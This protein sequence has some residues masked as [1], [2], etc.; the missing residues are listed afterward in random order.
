MASR[1]KM[2]TAIILNFVIAI[3]EVVGLIL[4]VQRHG[5]N[6]FAYYTENSNY[7]A[8]IVSI[9]F[10]IVVMMCL[11]RKISIP[12]W[13]INI[14]YLA[15][16]C[17]AITFLVVIFV[18]LPLRPSMANYLL[19]ESSSFIHHIVCPLISIVSFI[20]LE[21]SV[22]LNKKDILWGIIPTVVYG[23]ILITL[24]ILKVVVGPYPFL[25]VYEM[26]WYLSVL[27]CGGILSFG[28]TIAFVVKLLY[29]LTF[30][31]YMNK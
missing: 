30:K 11:V 8:L 22:C 6:V 9:V 3:L 25:Y 21:S 14:R 7:L 24:N 13:L 12:K 31:K 18:L 16:V 5:I 23:V 1:G 20:V 26:P 2:I 10:C 29:N 17:L 28:I 4:S 27:T 15:T 19:I